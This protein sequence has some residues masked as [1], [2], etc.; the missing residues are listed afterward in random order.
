MKLHD[1]LTNPLKPGQC[2]VRIVYESNRLDIIFAED[3]AE[4]WHGSL[5][6]WVPGTI[7]ND[8]WESAEC[9]PDDT[10]FNTP[11][12]VVYGITLYGVEAAEFI[13]KDPDTE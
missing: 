6:G 2:R 12:P 13:K 8:V 7:G 9:D 11:H 3:G 10:E 4:T 1:W 5:P